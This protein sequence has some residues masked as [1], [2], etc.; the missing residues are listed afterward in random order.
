MLPVEKQIRYKTM[1]Q[2]HFLID[3]SCTEF[4]AHFIALIYSGFI[5]SI[6]YFIESNN[7]K[8]NRFII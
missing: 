6:L 4:I 7:V 8:F 1:T 5:I 3:L 2:I